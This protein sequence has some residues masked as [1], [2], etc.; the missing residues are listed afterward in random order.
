MSNPVG[1]RKDGVWWKDEEDS[2]NVDSECERVNNECAKEDEN[3]V[4]SEAETD[5]RNGEDTQTRENEYRLVNS[6][7]KLLQ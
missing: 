6:R 4:D 3:Y 5:N 7:K 2:G 1:R